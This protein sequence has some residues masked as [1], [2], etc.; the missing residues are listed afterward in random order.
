MPH[1]FLP[2]AFLIVVVVILV[3][4][5]GCEVQPPEIS[6]LAGLEEFYKFGSDMIISGTFCFE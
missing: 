4:E 2:V 3:I 6:D 1:V 5:A